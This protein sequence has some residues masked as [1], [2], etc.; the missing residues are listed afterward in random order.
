ML[1]PSGLCFG[2][3]ETKIAEKKRDA[4]LMGR[5]QQMLGLKGAEEFTFESFRSGRGTMK[6]LNAA[7]NFAPEAEDLFF[8]GPAGTGKT[9]LAGAIVRKK[10]FA[11]GAWGVE[12]HKVPRL[13]RW[14]HLRKPSEQDEELDRL[15]KL[16]VLVLDDLGVE[17]DSEYNLGTLYE[18]LDARAM[19]RRHGLVITS[20]LG[21]EELA[22][23]MGDD[24]LPSRIFGMCAVHRL[25]APDARLKERP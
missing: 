1:S 2:C 16:E 5:L 22:A 23:K 3:I 12:F 14:F 8:T 6:A 10:L 21:P 18:L 7:R 24:R 15:A 9:H 25:E 19:S 17:K 13:L 4:M 11:T 20:N